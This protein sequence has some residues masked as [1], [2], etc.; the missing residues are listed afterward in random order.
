M[1]LKR[2]LRPRWSIKQFWSASKIC[3]LFP[4]LQVINMETYL[5][6]LQGKASHPEK[7]RFLWSCNRSKSLVISEPHAFFPSVKKCL[8]WI[9]CQSS[10]QLLHILVIFV[11]QHTQASCSSSPLTSKL[12]G[13]YSHQPVPDFSI[14]LPNL[15]TVFSETPIWLTITSL[16][17]WKTHLPLWLEL[18]D[19]NVGSMNYASWAQWHA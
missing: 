19:S 1:S 11:S 5:L 12:F 4:R 7:Q 16:S 2:L 3:W 17:S 6:F 15:S 13:S 18:K 10:N 8:R 9:V 14:S